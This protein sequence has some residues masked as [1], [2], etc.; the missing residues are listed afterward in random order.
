MKVFRIFFKKKTDR[1]TDKSCGSAE[2]SFATFK[3]AVN[4][5]WET[6]EEKGWR[7]A[8]VAELPTTMKPG[9]SGEVLKHTWNGVSSVTNSSN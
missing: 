1:S 4:W 9:D 2:V 8:M 7:V 5:A 6:A 3:E